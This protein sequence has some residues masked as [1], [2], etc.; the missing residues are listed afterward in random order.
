[1]LISH[2]AGLPL[3][4]P[5]FLFALNLYTIRQPAH[6]NGAGAAFAVEGQFQSIYNEES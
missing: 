5:A 6:F 2:P 4:G 3:C 1:M